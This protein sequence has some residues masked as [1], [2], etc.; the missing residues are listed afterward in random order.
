MTMHARF[1][2]S[3][4]LNVNNEWDWGGPFPMIFPQSERSYP[5]YFRPSDGLTGSYSESEG[6]LEHSGLQGPGFHLTYAQNPA[7]SEVVC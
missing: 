6:S 2:P 4:S 1:I 5:T 3:S 7:F